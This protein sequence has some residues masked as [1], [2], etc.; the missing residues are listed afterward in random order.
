MLLLQIRRDATSCTVPRVCL[1]AHPL[2]VCFRCRIAAHDALCRRI[3]RHLSIVYGRVALSRMPA[4]HQQGRP[5]SAH[6]RQP[7]IEYP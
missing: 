7:T 2:L 6:R 1:T 3:F 4:A 5:T